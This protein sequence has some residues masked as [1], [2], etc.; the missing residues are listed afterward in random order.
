M[1]W[2]RDADKLKKGVLIIHIP[3]QGPKSILKIKDDEA[4]R[5][6]TE[7]ARRDGESMTAVRERQETAMRERWATVWASEHERLSDF[8]LDLWLGR[9]EYIEVQNDVVLHSINFI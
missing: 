4:R 2:D 6:R 7:R 1:S 9:D 5:F 3:I 8:S